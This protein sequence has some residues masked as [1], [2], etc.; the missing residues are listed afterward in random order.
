MSR[1][2]RQ[3]LGWIVAAAVLLGGGYLAWS[4]RE[5]ITTALSPTASVSAAESPTPGGAAVPV[6][7][8]RPRAGGIERVCVQPGTVEP[9]EMADLY[10]KASGFLAEQSV[11]I[12]SRVKAGD[13]LARLSVPE[14]EKQVDRDKA[15]VR[16]AQAKVR[17]VEA[18]IQAAEADA[19]AADAAVGL[20]RVA[21]KA[22]SAYRQYRDKQLVRI[23]ELA[24]SRAVD[25]RLAD[26]QEDFY[27]S[28]VEGENTAKEQ[29]NA[30]LERAA[31]AKSKVVQGGADLD[32]AKANVGVADADLSKSEVLLGYTVVKS[33][34]TGVVTRRSFHPGDFVKA[35]DQG[36]TTPLLTVERTDKMRVVVQ[37]PD[38]DVAYVDA[39]DKAT[40]EIDALPGR[41]FAGAV[42]RT[43]EAEDPTTR[44]M[45]TE[46]DIPNTDGKL[47]RGMYGRAT[48]VLEAG[49]PG[50]VRV[51]SAAVLERQGA[52]AVIRVVQDG[53]VRH[54][55]VTL[56]AD[57]GTEIEVLSGL[58]P[59]EV[60]VVRASRPV[61]E[62]TAVS[63]TGSAH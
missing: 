27:Q 14:S 24:A 18:G 56:G 54:R 50:A 49:S 36:G 39:G 60:V 8:T 46:V 52:G 9:F 2:L 58:A 21:V 53:K 10:A 38:R 55:P 6:E 3:S 40:L 23:K 62:G 37:V 45:R 16:N 1:K 34:Y 57:N 4:Q 28:A 29:V 7:V 12:G 13:V 59:T 19:R 41:S 33:P 31:A 42:A 44:L 20:A 63:A 51:P 11:D 43:A 32:E 26:E 47:R 5:P 35:A 25:A 48:L 30:A 22:K 61:P 17:Q 15:R